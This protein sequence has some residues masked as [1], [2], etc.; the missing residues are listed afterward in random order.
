MKPTGIYSNVD[1]QLLP[2]CSAT[3][4]CEAREILSRHAATAQSGPS[5]TGTPGTSPLIS[6]Q[7]PNKLVK[8]IIKLST[9]TLRTLRAEKPFRPKREIK[10][11]NENTVCLLFG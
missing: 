4:P 2:K 1:L 8:H 5:K 11:L 10:T 7:I 3:T 9:L 6:E